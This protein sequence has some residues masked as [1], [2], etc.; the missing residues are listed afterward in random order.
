VKERI[1]YGADGHVRVGLYFFLCCMLLINPVLAQTEQPG[2]KLLGKST[3]RSVLLRWAP[4]SPAIWQYGNKYGYVIERVTLTVNGKVQKEPKKQILNSQPIKP[5]PE[6][7]WSEP[8]DN[9]DYVAIAAQAIF[10]ET[11]ELTNDYRSDIIQ[12]VNKARELES[13]FSFAV[14]A[15]DQSMEAARLSGLFYEDEAIAPDT[16]YLYRVYANIPLDI[17]QAD[18]GFVYIGLQDH[19]PLPAIRDLEVKFGDRGAMLSWNSQLLSK[20]Y[21]AFWVERSEDGKNF[22]KVTQRPVLNTFQGEEPTTAL[23]F[24][25]DSLPA[26]DKTYYYRVIGVDAFGESGPPSEIVSGSG[27]PEFNYSPTIKNAVVQKEVGVV[28][29]FVFPDESLPLIS[30]FDLVR[31]DPITKNYSPVITKA[32]KESRVIT[33]SVPETV[34]YYVIRATDKYG[35]ATYS[36]PYLVQLEDS[37][38]PH[39]PLGFTGKID[40]LGVVYLSWSKNSDNDIFGYSVFRANH[41]KDEFVQLPGRIVEQTIFF[42]TIKLD[43]LSKKIYYKLRAFD[44]RFNPSKF[45]QLLELKKPDKIPPAPAIFTQ[46]RN[47]SLGIYI[48]WE[49][50]PSEDVSWYL[51]YRKQSNDSLWTLLKSFQRHDLSYRFVDTAANH[52]ET[53]DYTLVVVDD[54][55][56]ESIPSPPIS[57]TR[58][59]KH[60]HPKIMNVFNYIEDDGKSV[61][62]GWSYNFDG[63]HEFLIYKSVNDGGLRLYKSVSR[64]T[65]E[66]SE[67]MIRPDNKIEYRIRA[68]FETGEFSPL[69]DPLIIKF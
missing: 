46:I 9:D 35:R 45:S 60:P 51:I 10:G 2:V 27:K 30:S 7:Y 68:Q 24:R 44:R 61:R 39:Q 26:N 12:V 32:L 18:T 13:R 55:G 17:I 65:K 22:M 43:N 64:A 58:V 5:L 57:L 11:F 63:V 14:F 1:S 41:P 59:S 40:S 67:K 42:D 29:D 8:M 19:K 53:Y 69:S 4:N 23:T 49:E 6:S 38:P 62:I 33:D 36:F 16:K 56:L 47:D 21:N 25:L 54:S 50:S 31:V 28:I 37:I 48:Q 20:I 3:D 15:A 34:N 66:I 52:K